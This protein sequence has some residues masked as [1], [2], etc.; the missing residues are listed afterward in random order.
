[1]YGGGLV[2]G[3][4]G[5]WIGGG[6]GG[7]GG[8]GTVG[9]GGGASFAAAPTRTFYPQK[10]QF[11]PPQVVNV[12]YAD[13]PLAQNAF[14]DYTKHVDARLAGE[15]WRRQ[16][17][18]RERNKRAKNS[19]LLGGKGEYYVTDSDVDGVKTGD[20]P[21]NTTGTITPDLSLGLDGGKNDGH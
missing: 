18:E 21:T 2:G 9:G 6:G 13:L 17:R 11:V 10:Q 19:P 20:Y 16:T 7:G 8:G 14:M 1:M 12:T 15:A 4:G 5:G 3:G